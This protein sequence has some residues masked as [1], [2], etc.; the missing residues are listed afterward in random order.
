M[1][2]LISHIIT[3]KKHKI[4][5]RMMRSKSRVNSSTKNYM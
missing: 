5:P 3:S 1:N 2:I 4:S